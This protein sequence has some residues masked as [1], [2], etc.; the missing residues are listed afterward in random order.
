M[1]GLAVLHAV[2]IMQLPCQTLQHRCVA[3]PEKGGHADE[4]TKAARPA[5]AS[6]QRAKAEAAHRKV[7]ARREAE[8]K[9]RACYF[10]FAGN[11]DVAAFMH[12]L[13]YDMAASKDASP[14]A[15]FDA[16][17]QVCLRPYFTIHLHGSCTSIVVTSWRGH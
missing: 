4:G 10:R 17:V 8:S 15:R 9:V 13:G 11:C 1:S 2:T 16:A 14:A 7:I 3:D 12:A 5:S 6:S